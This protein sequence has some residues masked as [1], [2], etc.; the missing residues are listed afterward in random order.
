M[1]ILKFSVVCM[2]GLCYSR[3]EGLY[4]VYLCSLYGVCRII[5]TS[6]SLLTLL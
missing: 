1:G 6:S 4:G 3:E 5:L 2:D